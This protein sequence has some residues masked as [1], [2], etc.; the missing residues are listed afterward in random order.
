MAKKST[1]SDVTA[2]L[3][4]L[5]VL[6]ATLPKSEPYV[7]VHHPAFRVGKK[8]FVI[9]GIR[10]AAD[11]GAVVSVNLGQ[12]AQAQL[13]DDGRFSKTPYLG[14]HGWVSIPV[15]ALK[16][17]ELTALV[18]ESWRRIAGKKLLA[19]LKADACTPRR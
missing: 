6:C 9:A 16:R 14:Q 1:R 2:L 4:E 18:T 15:S 11:G 19:A 10:P 3:A 13:L 17:G 7:M 12:E 8:P 5:Q